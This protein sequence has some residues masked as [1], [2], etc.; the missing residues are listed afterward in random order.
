M[1]LL[2]QA[3]RHLESDVVV[4]IVGLRPAAIALDSCLPEIFA[5]GGSVGPEEDEES[6][7]GDSGAPPEAA[8]PTSTSSP[9]RLD[10]MDIVHH[11]SSIRGR[12]STADYGPSE[13]AGT[14]DARDRREEERAEVGMEIGTP[15]AERRARALA[16]GITERAVAIDI[17]PEVLAASLANEPERITT[18]WDIQQSIDC[19]WSMLPVSVQDRSTPDSPSCWESLL[20]SSGGPS[21]IHEDTTVDIFISCVLWSLFLVLVLFVLMSGWAHGVI[22]RGGLPGDGIGDDENADG[23][24]ADHGTT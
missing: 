5:I 4:T 8:R 9:H 11:G 19:F 7:S 13:S 15:R 12:T 21:H 16:A 1:N 3:R 20:W 14:N 2:G 17:Q 6:E 24:A 18:A 10:E 23:G 22:S